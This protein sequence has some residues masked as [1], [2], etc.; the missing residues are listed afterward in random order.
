[1]DTRAPA[2]PPP[3]PRGNDP[4]TTRPPAAYRNPADPMQH[5]L[6]PQQQ[7]HHQQKQVW[8]AEDATEDEA[9]ELQR[10]REEVIDVPLYSM[11]HCTR[12][13][14]VLDAPLYCW[15]YHH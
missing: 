8:E 10:I 15:G 12:C 7:H 3:K 13:I 5:P 2:L 9:E 4:T 6:E 1:M 11:Y 14:T